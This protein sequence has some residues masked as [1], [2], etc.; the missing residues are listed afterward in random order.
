MIGITIIIITIIVIIVIVIIIIII[1]IIRRAA[2]V[3]E[4]PRRQSCRPGKP[5][6]KGD[7]H[8]LAH[9]LRCSSSGPQRLMFDDTLKMI[10]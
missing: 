7:G 10:D 1:I 9:L 4:G 3:E 2:E 8:V 6:M 5:R